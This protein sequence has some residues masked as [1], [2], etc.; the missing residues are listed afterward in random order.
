MQKILSVVIAFVLSAV[1]AVGGAA[2]F[3]T[4]A[5]EG[6]RADA[7]AFLQHASRGDIDRA[8]AYAP[9]EIMRQGMPAVSAWIANAKLTQ[10]FS[11]DWDVQRWR[12]GQVEFV[13]RYIGENL[14]P[15][16][17]VM[18]VTS[19]GGKATVS[20]FDIA[21]ASEVL[22]IRQDEDVLRLTG[23]ALSQLTRTLAPIEPAA[24][25]RTDAAR[26]EIGR[27]LQMPT[28]GYQVFAWNLGSDPRDLHAEGRIEGET[29]LR[30]IFDWRH[31]GQR[32]RLVN[33][34]LRSAGEP[35]F[36][37]LPAAPAAN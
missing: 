12:P 10:K 2:L 31:D 13:G 9:T 32:W 7:E 34:R 27:A 29:D 15:R 25:A 16:R 30:F 18:T 19:R 14:P 20:R 33:A 5:T 1:L 26:E 28:T 22:G 24:Q 23:P 3:I 6:P 4:W 11:V 21:S 36:A 8:S 37:G 35:P 17:L